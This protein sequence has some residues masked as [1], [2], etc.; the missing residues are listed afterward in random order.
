MSRDNQNSDYKF[1]NN[2]RVGRSIKDLHKNERGKELLIIKEGRI[3]EEAIEKSTHAVR[4]VSFDVCKKAI[5]MEKG[6]SGRSNKTRD[7]SGKI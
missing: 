6:R 2:Y 3:K 7:R 4:A 5:E 1:C